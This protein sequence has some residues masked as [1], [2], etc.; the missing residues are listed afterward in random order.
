MVERKERIGIGIVT[1]NRLDYLKNLLNSVKFCNWAEL[2][3]VNDG[4]HIEN[5]EGYNY[6]LINNDTNLGVGKS[7][8]KAM[9]HL[10][11][12]GCD[13]IFI[14]ED[15]M[16]IL[17]DSVF[18]KYIQA[19]RV[20]GI[21]HMM[22]AY[23]GPA[24]KGGISG[25]KPHPRKIIDYGDIKLSLNQHCVGSFCFYTRKCLEDVGL[26]DEEFDKNN[27]EHVEHSYRLSKA[28][29]STPYWWW[30]DLANSTDYI[31][32]QA[33]SEVSSSIRRGNDWLEKIRWSAMLFEKKHGY[34]PAWN[35]A[36][37]DSSIN[38]IISF[39]KSIT[40]KQ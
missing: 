12:K 32:E 6:Y 27:F 22:F 39:L 26:M 36:V 3:I 2:V 35:N 15:D 21:Q 10:L 9:Q 16:I 31:Q 5:L 34:M 1:C 28:G 23:H 18:D 33:C 37:P 40:P 29:Y 7:K 4:D 14:I 8:N 24:N 13:Y 17:D 25:G 30:S 11:D 38:Q 19:S 20:T